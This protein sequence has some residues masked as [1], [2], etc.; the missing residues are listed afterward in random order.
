MFRVLL[1]SGLLALVGIVAPAQAQSYQ[2]G[3]PLAYYHPVP[4]VSSYGVYGHGHYGYRARRSHW[5]D[6]CRCATP[7][8]YGRRHM[9]RS[10]T[11]YVQA[12]QGYAPAYRPRPVYRARPV[13]RSEPVYGYAPAYRHVRQPVYTSRPGYAYRPAP[14]AQV[15]VEGQYQRRAHRPMV[16]SYAEV[17]R[18]YGYA[19]RPRPS[20]RNVYSNA[21]REDAGSWRTRRDG[22]VVI[23][24]RNAAPRHVPHGGDAYVRPGRNGSVVVTAPGRNSSAVVNVPGRQMHAPGEMRHQPRP[25]P[26]HRPE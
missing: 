19:Y 9:A 1:A 5:D 4:N 3:F 13:Y 24:P 25:H 14:R 18:P 22:V 8:A 23:H 15:Y 2:P 6:N 12:D 21:Y 7:Y 20:H 11:V 17:D 26:R 16:R 10:Q